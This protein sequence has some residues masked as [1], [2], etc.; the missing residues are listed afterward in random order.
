R[1]RVRPEI[2][3]LVVV[4]LAIAAVLTKD[5]RPR[6]ALRVGGG[7]DEPR[8]DRVGRDEDEID[9]LL[10]GGLVE[11]PAEAL[12]VRRGQQPHLLG[13]LRR[14]LVQH[15]HDAACQREAPHGGAH[16][17]RAP[18]AAAVHGHLEHHLPRDRLLPAVAPRVPHG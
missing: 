4:P 14:R 7:V 18:L 1:A 11:A 10:A 13:G 5:R 3:L 9:L 15:L 17:G 2:Q 16:L 6:L 8:L 12:G